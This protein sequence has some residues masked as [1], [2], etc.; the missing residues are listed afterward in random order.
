[1]ETLR[2]WQK[3]AELVDASS[4][5][6]ELLE[7]ALLFCSDNEHCIH[8]WIKPKVTIVL[9]DALDHFKMQLVLIVLDVTPGCCGCPEMYWTDEF[10]MMTVHKKH[11]VNLFVQ[12][13]K[14]SQRFGFNN[15]L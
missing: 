9:W 4:R 1:M 5:T 6:M 15:K 11:N 10:H 14:S 7:S 8:K 12:V 13:Y 2:K 3:G